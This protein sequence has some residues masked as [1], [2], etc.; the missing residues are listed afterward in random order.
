[1]RNN[2]AS[3]YSHHWLLVSFRVP[4]Q[5]QSQLLLRPPSQPQLWKPTPVSD[6]LAASTSTSAPVM[7]VPDVTTPIAVPVA[8]PTPLSTPPT[9]TPTQQRPTVTPA[10]IQEPPQDIPIPPA[11]LPTSAPAT[12]PPPGPSSQESASTGPRLTGRV[13]LSGAR[14][15][16]TQRGIV[17]QPVVEEVSVDAFPEDRLARAQIFVMDWD[18]GGVKQ[19]TSNSKVRNGARY[20]SWS[21]DNSQIVYFPI[22]TLSPGPSD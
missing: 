18:G 19:L 1:M 10:V 3:R 15:L 14:E 11:S 22:R 16:F 12:V 4:K 21:P 13:V 2:L 9:P 8:V 20:A 5:S 6:L 7:V 17:L